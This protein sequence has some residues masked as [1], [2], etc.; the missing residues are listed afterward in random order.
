LAETLGQPIGTVK[1]N[2]HRGIRQ[3]RERMSD[4]ELLGGR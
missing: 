4:L 3:L 2:V 1:A